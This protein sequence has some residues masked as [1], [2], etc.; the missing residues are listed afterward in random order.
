MK[1]TINGQPI[2]FTYDGWNPI[3][4][5]DTAGN[6]TGSNIYGA[7]S[8]EII[9]RWTPAHGHLRYH[10]DRLGNVTHAFDYN[11]NLLEKYTYDAFGEPTITNG[12]GSGARS[13]SNYGN[14][15]MFTGREWLSELGIYDY[16]HRMYDPKL[17]RFLQPDPIGFA[18][19]DANLFRYCGGDPVNQIDL[20]GLG[21]EK[22]RLSGGPPPAPK[23][24]IETWNPP[25]PPM[26]QR[27]DGSFV[28]YAVAGRTSLGGGDWSINGGGLTNADRLSLAE[29]GRNG[30]GAFTGPGIITPFVREDGAGT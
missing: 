21:S 6:H 18:A 3:L 13:R 4:E 17:G 26:V 7:K 14:R 22:P 12:D 20:T 1:R 8:D 5:W 15:F 24:P 16:R 10:S 23:R 2:F 9:W 28:P 30:F 27:R 19:G 11:G 25:S 29:Q